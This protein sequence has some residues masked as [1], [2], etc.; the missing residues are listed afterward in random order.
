MAESLRGIV[1]VVGRVRARRPLVHYV[2][3]LVTAGHVADALLAAGASPVMAIAVEEVAA[4]RRDAL[5]LNLGTPTA[6]RLAALELAGRSAAAQ[7]VPIVL[8]PVG[9][10]ASPF[11][12]QAALRLLAAC[13]V[14]VLRLNAGEATALLGGNQT[15]HGVDAGQVSESTASLAAAL[16]A[17]F[18]LVAAVT[19]ATDTV[20]D[21]RRTAEI[22]NGHPLLARLTGAGCIATGLVA[23]CAAVEPDPFRAAVAGLLLLGVAGERSAQRASGPGTLRPVLLD[24]LAAVTADDIEAGSQLRWG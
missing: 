11:R 2:P 9:V 18:G 7:V 6:E 5:A 20:S 21:G 23:A 13:P 17:R 12:L 4:L 14:A 19:G 22:D 15:G 10:G 3:N 8:D 24:E 16:A 1:D